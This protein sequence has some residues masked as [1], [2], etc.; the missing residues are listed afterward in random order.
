MKRKNENKSQNNIANVIGSNNTLY[1]FN[2]KFNIDLNFFAETIKRQHKLYPYFATGI[3]KLPNGEIGF[4]SIP[5]NEEAKIK[6]PLSIESNVTVVDDKYK[7]YTDFDK[8][9]QDSYNNQE[10]IKVKVNSTVQKL[11]DEI[12]PYQ[13]FLDEKIVN[14]YIFPQRFPSVPIVSIGFIDTDFV[15]DGIR[16]EI[17]KKEENNITYLSNEKQDSFIIVHIKVIVSN[18]DEEKNKADM[19]FKFNFNI[20]SR[21][22]ENLDASIMFYKILLNIAEG[23]EMYMKFIDE[24]QKSLIGKL[25]AIDD[26]Q[27]FEKIIRFCEVLKKINSTFNLNLSRFYNYTEQDY[28]SISFLEN[29]LL[30]KIDDRRKK[31]I[32]LGLDA[33][34]LN[35]DMIKNLLKAGDENIGEIRKGICVPLANNNLIISQIVKIYKNYVIKNKEKLIE[36]MESCIEN[37][38]LKV[39]LIPKEDYI[40]VDINYTI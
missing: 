7:D 29:I 30:P 24:P 2:N 40:N 17:V 35:E 21:Y 25:E 15:V 1:Q 38:V 27:Y 22:R 3:D 19:Q 31:E 20:N 32:V 13:P 9:L 18:I 6:Y 10:P 26:A 4:K 8:I 33:T 36:N 12:D 34:K 5:I 37:N 28:K 14:A 23:K 16:L 11:G 39:V